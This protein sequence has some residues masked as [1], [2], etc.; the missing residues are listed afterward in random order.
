MLRFIAT[1]YLLLVMAFGTASA[2]I[3]QIQLNVVFRD[4]P[5]TFTALETFY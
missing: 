1:F 4:N 3:T 2:L 5:I